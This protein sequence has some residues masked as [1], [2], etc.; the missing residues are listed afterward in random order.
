MADMEK[1]E[2]DDKKTRKCF[3][4]YVLLLAS[5]AKKSFSFAKRKVQLLE[6]LGLE[7]GTL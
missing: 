6:L 2:K 4:N 7:P 5:L 3:L 1:K